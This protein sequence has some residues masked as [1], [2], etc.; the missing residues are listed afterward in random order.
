MSLPQGLVQSLWE[1]LSSREKTI[2]VLKRLHFVAGKPLPRA[3]DFSLMALT[4]NLQRTSAQSETRN[5]QL[6][7]RGLKTE[8]K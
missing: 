6:H 1:R 7:I 3:V 2:T 5:Q 4:R 8:L